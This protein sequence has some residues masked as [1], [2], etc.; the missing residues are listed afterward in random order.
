MAQPGGASGGLAGACL[1]KPEYENRQT[2]DNIQTG[3][4][5]RNSDTPIL[6][7]RPST[8]WH[9]FRLVPGQ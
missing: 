4:T 1:K 9:S 6:D 7:A 5:H 8:S 3:L 2:S